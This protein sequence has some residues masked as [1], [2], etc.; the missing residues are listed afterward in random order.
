MATGIIKR[1]TDSLR[2]TLEHGDSVT[3]T[4]PSGQYMFYAFSSYATLRK[5]T[6]LLCVSGGSIQMTNV[7]EYSTDNI[8]ITSLNPY[9]LTISNQH[10]SATAYC[11][12][13]VFDS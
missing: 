8:P 3:L 7:Y 10:A 13:T 9:E 6:M 11:W 1:P 2:I 4:L 5:E 12:L